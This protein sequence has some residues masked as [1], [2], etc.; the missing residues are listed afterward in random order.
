VDV[1]CDA[2]A[3]S[4][5]WS[6]MRPAHELRVRELIL[7]QHPNVVVSISSEIAPVLGEY[8]RTASTVVNAYLT[9]KVDGYIA[10]LADRP[11]AAGVEP[12]RVGMLSHGGV[13]RVA[14]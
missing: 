6:Y 2:I 9:K 5:L 12:L 4:L 14:A 7:A 11:R 1:G 10:A 8:E 3:V 13:P